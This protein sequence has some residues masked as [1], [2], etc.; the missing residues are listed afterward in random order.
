MFTPLFTLRGEHSTV[1]KNGGVN[2][3][4]HPQ[5]ITSPSRGQNS[6]LGSKFAPRGE[7]KNGPLGSPVVG[8]ENI[9]C[10]GREFSLWVKPFDKTSLVG[11]KAVLIKLPL[12][13][14]ASK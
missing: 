7:V 12:F 11:Q 9:S 14:S 10:T 4:F 2:G 6:P 13:E 1:L 8:F 3:E 5:G